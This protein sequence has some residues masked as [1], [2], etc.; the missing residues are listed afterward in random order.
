MLPHAFAHRVCYKISPSP[1]AFNLSS[2]FFSSPLSSL[3]GHRIFKPLFLILI[4]LFLFPISLKRHCC[5]YVRS[6]FFSASFGIITFL[7]IQVL[8]SALLRLFIFQENR[9]FNINSLLFA[10]FL[11]KNFCFFIHYSSFE[12]IFRY[13][14]ARSMSQILK[15]SFIFCLSFGISKL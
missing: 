7:L 1:V 3:L 13:T 12:D 15:F 2:E 10:F 6:I 14:N 5:S 4:M 9:Y 8:P 11:M